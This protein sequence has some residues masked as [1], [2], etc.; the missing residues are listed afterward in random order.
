MLTRDELLK[1]PDCASC[2]YACEGKP[3]RPVF[4]QVPKRIAGVV[5]AE[6]PGEREVE[7][8][9]PLSGPTGQQFDE[10]LVAAGL[11]RQELLILNAIAC[12]PGKTAK[13]NEAN[14][15]AA[16][17]ACRPLMQ[18]QLQQAP[19]SA[20]VFV[21]GKWAYV[22]FTER[23]PH[24][25]VKKARGF[26]RRRAG[27][28]FIASYH[29]TNAFFHDPWV[30]GDFCTDLQRFARAVAGKLRPHPTEQ[31][32]E[33]N[34]TPKLIH[35]IFREWGG[36]GSCD[37][38]TASPSRQAPWLGKDPT[39]ALLKVMGFGNPWRAVSFVW[40]EAT[41]EVKQACADAFKSY[42][43]IGQNFIWYDDRVCKRYGLAAQDVEDTRDGRKAVVTT[44]L[45]NLGY[46]SCCYTDPDPWKEEADWSFEPGDE[47]EEDEEVEEVE[48]AAD[49]KGLVFA[50]DPHAQRVYNGKDNI[51]QAQVWEG[52]LAEQ[53]PQGEPFSHPRIQ[54]LYRQ[55]LAMSRIAA[56]MHTTGFY[57]DQ[58]R[59]L[60]LAELLERQYRKRLACLIERV[61]QPA[62][63]GTPDQMR[64]LI[65]ESQEVPELQGYGL[66]D[67]PPVDS[68][69]GRLLWTP[70]GKPR[71]NQSSLLRVVIDTDVSKELRDVIELYWTAQ[72][73][74][75]A[76]STF[77]TSA[78]VERAIGA[79]SRLR[80]G[81][82][83][84]GP[85]TGRWSC[86]EPQIMNLPESKE[87]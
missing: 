10:E 57:V 26:V 82:N 33:L 15:G 12:L 1:L 59:R 28:L 40:D 61:G 58:K 47:E 54:A 63:R 52:L 6:S 23:L 18:A 68:K 13:K 62:F 86:S 53:T 5:L 80:P 48:T 2:P 60:H 11:Q 71:V 7:T 87:D 42:K 41:P 83:S 20:P 75:K 78:K 50:A 34:V 30:W 22:S 72:T 85:D 65:F 44:S 46:L 29:P 16:V 45:L 81:W 27:R 55:H 4:A 66:A 37:V 8:G 49:E 39:Q 17:R 69:E 64:A 38:E 25:G 19:A 43:L 3:V 9:I 36:K 24:S 21:A 35:E 70:S 67:P 14:M 51:Y 56:E 77:V 74:R 31:Q 79:D 73:T 84:C 32:V 76:R